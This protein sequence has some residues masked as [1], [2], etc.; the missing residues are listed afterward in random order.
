MSDFFEMRECLEQILKQK[1]HEELVRVPAPR[2][3]SLR[4]RVL[5]AAAVVVLGSAVGIQQ[6]VAKLQEPV[7]GVSKTHCQE[8]QACTKIEFIVKG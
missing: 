5:Q 2:K 7:G 6:G 3:K 4:S 8:G 1:E